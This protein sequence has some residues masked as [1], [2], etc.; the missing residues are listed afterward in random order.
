[1]LCVFSCMQLCFAYRG[2]LPTS[3]RASTY[4][5][6]ADGS[7]IYVYIHYTLLPEEFPP[8]PNSWT[9]KCIN[10]FQFFT[11]ESLYADEGIEFSSSQLYLAND[12]LWIDEVSIQQ[13]QNQSTSYSIVLLKLTSYSFILQ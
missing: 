6:L 8:S 3:L 2:Y 10:M 13:Q 1:M 5:N 9:H 12:D 11:Q 7:M 4:V